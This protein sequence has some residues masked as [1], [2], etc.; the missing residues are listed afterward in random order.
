MR[1][2]HLVFNAHLDP[3][4]LWPWSAGLDEIVNT[5]ETA[6]AILERNPDVIFTRGEAWVY[7]MIE[8]LHPSLFR[9]IRKLVKAGRW[10]VIGGWY[11][12]PDC[13][14]PGGFA[15]EKQIALGREYFERTF[16]HFPK[17]AY[18]VDSFGHGAALPELIAAAGQTHYVMMRPMQD[19]KD[20][21]SRLF[22][23]RGRDGGKEIVT[24]R[25]SEC[26][27][28]PC[29][30]TLD[31]IAGSLAALPEGVTDTMCFL[32]VGDHG[33]GPTEEM[34][35]FCREHREAIP[36]VRLEFS[37]P[38]RFFAA[39]GRQSHSLP[40]VTGE[41]Q[42]HAI[43]CYSVHR[44]IK[45]G[46]RRA[47]HLL[48]EADVAV[49][50]DPQLEKAHR[51]NLENAWRWTCFHHFHDTLG[52]TCIPSAYDQV[53]AQLGFSKAVAD[54]V[55]QYALRRK[56]SAL[57]PDR[58]QRLV[59]A[60]YSG[61]DFTGWIEHE[62]WL[63]WTAWQPHWRL[64]DEKGRTIPH[65][66]MAHEGIHGSGKLARLLFPLKISG[67]S[68]RI[69]RITASGKRMNRSSGTPALSIRQA[70][71]DGPL[72]QWNNKDWPAPVFQ[73]IEDRSDTWSH[74]LHSFD[75]KVIANAKWNKV[76]QVDH[77]PL[78]NS[79]RMDGKIGKSLLEAEWRAYAGEDFLEL[80]LRVIWLEVFRILRLAWKPRGEILAREDG[81]SSGSLRRE[82]D[83]REYNAHDWTL[84]SLSGGQNAGVIFP[85]T[86]SLSS[87]G[88]E[89]RLTLLRSA[90]M[91]HHL[92]DTP[93]FERRV[94][95]DQGVQTFFFRFY[96][97]SVRASTMIQHALAFHRRPLVSDLTRG[98]PWRPVRNQVERPL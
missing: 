92:P 62:P 96:P 59:I 83:G 48:M 55:L 72:F 2:I 71:K 30:I 70:A 67:N 37:S 74:C 26:Y 66:V 73:L 81:I 40:L 42:M 77:G 95:S 89:L 41:L 90:V 20:L 33:G 19:E 6:C 23:W 88:G 8:K 1:T 76:R 54:E 13:N 79:W 12:Q 52:G 51:H 10:E 87:A 98:M 97:H 53:D 9:R 47:E 15:L 57:P 38:S 84:L 32:G 61:A 60:N 7:E 50:Q 18:N 69:L 46:V 4:W 43:G 25:I 78:L 85:D 17:I 56:S 63:E 94:V 86:Y 64:I 27:C 49:K 24:Y 82:N 75:G 11:V 44:S 14:L 91:A 80:R 35:A 58:C 5:C 16:G 22:R 34:I 31:H 21:P 28:T 39:V 93:D 29:G 65:Q 68:L 3:V 45:L 36:G